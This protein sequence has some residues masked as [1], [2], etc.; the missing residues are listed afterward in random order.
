MI[1]NPHVD[2]HKYD[3]INKVHTP[4]IIILY[5]FGSRNTQ[6][7]PEPKRTEYLYFIQQI[8]VVT[9]I[10]TPA[11]KFNHATKLD[12]QVLFVRSRIGGAALCSRC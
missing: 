8:D 3:K 2:E 5:G 10:V 4:R 11:P 7:K 6:P 1:Q 9:I 12:N